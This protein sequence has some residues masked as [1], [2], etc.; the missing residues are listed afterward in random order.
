MSAGQRNLQIFGMA[1]SACYYTAQ[2]VAERPASHHFIG[3]NSFLML[4]V[5]ELIDNTCEVYTND[6]S[7]YLALLVEH[8]SSTPHHTGPLNATHP[9]Y[10][11]LPSCAKTCTLGHLKLSVLLGVFDSVSSSHFSCFHRLCH[12]P[13]TQ[14]ADLSPDENIADYYDH[15]SALPSDDADHDQQSVDVACKSG[16]PSFQRRKYFSIWSSSRGVMDTSWCCI[17]RSIFQAK[18][19]EPGVWLTLRAS[20]LYLFIMFS[21]LLLFFDV[22]LVSPVEAGVR[23]FVFL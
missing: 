16:I 2:A 1:R 13:S 4:L 15:N 20:A 5:D 22:F 14:P 9:G 11:T 6:P 8:L 12:K 10:G 19:H 23:D 3:M 21:A 7:S 17:L 18:I